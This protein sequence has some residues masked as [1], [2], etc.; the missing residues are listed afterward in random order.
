MTRHTPP[1]ICTW[2]GERFEPLRRFEQLCNKQF[3]VGERYALVEHHERSAES[4]GH[5]FA[6]LKEAWKNLR[7]GDAARFPSAEHLRKWA[8][9]KAGYFDVRDI[10]CI[11]K[12]E[13][14]RAAAHIRALDGYAVITISE[15]VVRVYTA[16]SQSKAAMGAKEFQESKQAV[17]DIVSGMVGVSVGDLHREAGRSA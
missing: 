13:A 16:R 15:G 11:S 9:V 5:Y 7:E 8:L 6:S 1:I 14:S 10:A 3:V 2:D 17:L 4:Q 12:G